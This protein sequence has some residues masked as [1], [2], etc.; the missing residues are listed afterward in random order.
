MPSAEVTVATPFA[1]PDLLPERLAG[2]I[3]DQIVSGAWPPGTRLVELVLCKQAGV[4]RVP[5]REALRIVAADGF[6]VLEAHRG[7]TVTSLSNNELNELFGLRIALEGFASAEVARKQPSESLPS[8]RRLVQ[9]MRDAVGLGE[10]DAYHALAAL[11]HRG[12]VRAAGNALL[13][14]TYERLRV[15][16]RRYQAEMALIPDLPARSIEDHERILDAVAA[17]HAETARTRA[18]RHLLELV[19][20][21]RLRHDGNP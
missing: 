15:R 6:V 4:S 8:L 7:A 17:G 5:L 11:F 19:E 13:T 16:L 20:S 18:E 1:K 12:L 14:E 3:R 21:F 9:E 2:W 10:L